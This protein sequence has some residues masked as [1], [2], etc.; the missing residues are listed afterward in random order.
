MT[1]TLTTYH[2]AIHTALHIL[3]ADMCY[4]ISPRRLRRNAPICAPS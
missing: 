4:E 3:A 2:E 1:H